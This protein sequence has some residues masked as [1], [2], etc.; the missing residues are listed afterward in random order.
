MLL[1][2]TS[3]KAA[4]EQATKATTSKTTAVKG[5]KKQAKAKTPLPPAEQ[6]SAEA[7][8][9]ATTASNVASPKKLAARSERISALLQKYLNPSSNT[10]TTTEA[11]STA[12]ASDAASVLPTLKAKLAKRRQKTPVSDTPTVAETQQTSVPQ[13][14]SEI[15]PSPRQLEAAVLGANNR[16]RPA[17]K[18]TI[19]QVKTEQDR[20]IKELQHASRQFKANPIPLSVAEPKL[21]KVVGNTT[22]GASTASEN[23][24]FS[25]I[26][27]KPNPTAIPESTMEPRYALMVAENV[28]KENKERPI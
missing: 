21:V 3:N 28:L 1:S 25:T 16:D 27:Y 9:P 15:V 10:P 6:P 11:T 5:K 23:S 8:P 22:G 14:A 19:M 26:N 24:V 7:S 12:P 13:T 20:A 18:K 17:K 4:K 2:S